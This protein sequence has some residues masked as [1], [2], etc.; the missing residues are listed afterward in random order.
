MPL[1]DWEGSE[2]VA[3]RWKPAVNSRRGWGEAG[4]I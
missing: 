1:V 2:G 3:F 4:D